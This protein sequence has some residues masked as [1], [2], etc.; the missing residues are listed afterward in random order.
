MNLVTIATYN[1]PQ[2]L[3]IA[4][5]KLEANGIEC[6]VK[7]ELT[8]QV[9]NFLSNAIGGVKLQVLESDA[10]KARKILLERNDLKADYSESKLK[11]PNCESGN[12]DG[13][14]L[15]GRISMIFFFILGFPIPIFSN[16]FKCYDCD[17]VF[18]YKR[19]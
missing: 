1:L 15:N 18:K 4:K 5:A 19:R 13:M 17:H 16:K 7:D 11:C 2:Q 8:A 6:F 14:G 12:I 3:I 10:N 9:H